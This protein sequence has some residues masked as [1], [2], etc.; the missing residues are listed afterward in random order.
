VEPK[1]E[2]EAPSATEAPEPVEGGE[3]PAPSELTEAQIAELPFHN[4]PRF[5]EIVGQ[6]N[7][8]K[9][10]LQTITAKVEELQRPAEQ[11]GNVREFMATNSLSD[12]D[13]LDM[14]R[15]G[16]LLRTDPLAGRAAI[17]EYLSDI[18]L[19]LG[20][21]LP[22]DL[23]EDVDAGYMSEE[24]ARELHQARSTASQAE[25]TAQ[26]QREREE[27]ARAV[28]QQT[29]HA[30]QLTSAAKAWEAA[31]RARDPDFD[32]KQ[33]L[34]V[35]RMRS[36]A[37]AERLQP[38]TAADI[39]ALLDRAHQDVTAQLRRFVPAPKP[40]NRPPSGAPTTVATPQPMTMR[41]AIAQAARG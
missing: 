35:D 5:K 31:K 25:A 32:A 28:Q 17:A 2:P 40:V 22:P 15:M 9:S 37:A 36:I 7:A 18:D 39:N 33:D 12:Q 6:K 34:I 16:A 13:M 19:A 4:H 10:E 3:T 1:A 8:L 41:E 38:R 29:E 21:R 27:Q 20:L 26:A 24:R 11:W 23:Q 14:F 30:Q